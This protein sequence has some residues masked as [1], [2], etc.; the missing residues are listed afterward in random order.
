MPGRPAHPRRTTPVMT[1]DHRLRQ[2]ECGVPAAVTPRPKITLIQ[3]RHSALLAP[4]VQRPRQPERSGAAQGL[5]I[6]HPM[7]Q[8]LLYKAWLENL[9]VTAHQD[10]GVDRGST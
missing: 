7:R 1:G 6:R 5:V 4:R 9:A 3:L 10:R 2:A 8:L